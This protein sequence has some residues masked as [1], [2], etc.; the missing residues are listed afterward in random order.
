ME[1]TQSSAPVGLED[2]LLGGEPLLA[3][4]FGVPSQCFMIIKRL[5]GQ[6]I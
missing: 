1:E 6:K 3:V 4:T 5:N 2:D